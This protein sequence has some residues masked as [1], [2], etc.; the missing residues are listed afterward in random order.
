[1]TN[2][3]KL[4]Q[5][6]DTQH[7][8]EHIMLDGY[9]CDYELLNDKKLVKSILEALPTLLGMRKLSNPEVYFV[10]GNNKKDPGGWTGI[11]VIEESHISI[12]TFPKR[13]FVSVDVYTCGDNLDSDFIKK[14]FKKKFK[15][16]QL[17]THFVIRG[18][19]YP[20]YNVY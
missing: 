5:N 8:G 16:N 19:Q 6:K 3:S 14:Y 15:I 4:K 12:H 20:K 13:G 9:G 7:F 1:M 18:K 10:P 2:F 11:V 17:E